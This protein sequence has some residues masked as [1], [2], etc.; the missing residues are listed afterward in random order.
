MYKYDSICNEGNTPAR[1]RG[2]YVH[3][4]GGGVLKFQWVDMKAKH[5]VHSL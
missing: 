5:L 2:G 3:G 4:Q 1:G